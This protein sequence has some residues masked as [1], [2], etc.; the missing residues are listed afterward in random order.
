MAATE[1]SFFTGVDTSQPIRQHDINLYTYIKGSFYISEDGEEENNLHNASATQ[2]HTTGLHTHTH[3]LALAHKR[4]SSGKFTKQITFFVSKL[5]SSVNHT[6]THYVH[7]L[8]RQSFE[9]NESN[10]RRIKARF[11][12]CKVGKLWTTNTPQPLRLND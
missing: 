4:S 11:S 8:K 9:L 7:T 10:N 6:L 2:R 12:C 5:Q 1:S 3:T